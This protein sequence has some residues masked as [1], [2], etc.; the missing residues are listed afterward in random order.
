MSDI[1]SEINNVSNSEGTG[2]IGL[3]DDRFTIYQ[4]DLETKRSRIKYL[5]GLKAFVESLNTCDGHN[6]DFSL[7]GI[8]DPTKVDNC[9]LESGT[10]GLL[11]NSNNSVLLTEDNFLTN[12]CKTKKYDYLGIVSVVH[13]LINK[14]EEMFSII[15]KLEKLNFNNY[16][17]VSMYLYVRTITEKDKLREFLC[18][19]NE[20]EDKY[21]KW[22]LILRTIYMEI[23]R[24]NVLDEKF[25]KELIE[26]LFM[27]SN[28]KNE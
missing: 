21:R 17:F 13:Q 15:E 26:S 25:D 16:F 4:Y 12:V 9:D 11:C 1:T 19:K 6:Y 5:I 7:I 2:T 22:K 14:P 28:E 23:L 8:D 10:L 3:V 24:F 27:Q 18:Q 20:E